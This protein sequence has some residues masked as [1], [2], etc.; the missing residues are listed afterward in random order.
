MK[1]FVVVSAFFAMLLV[2]WELAAESGRWSP[3]LFPSAV[4]VAQYLWGAM[5]DGTLCEAIG[6]T[7]QR[8]LVG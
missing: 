3:V 8:L 4:S 6:V 2:L 5:T 1:R 7:L